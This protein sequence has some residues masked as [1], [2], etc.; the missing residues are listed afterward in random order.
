MIRGCPSS[1][2][3]RVPNLFRKNSCALI[4]PLL[5]PFRLSGCGTANHL[6]ILRSTGSKKT[7]WANYSVT[8]RVTLIEASTFWWERMSGGERTGYYVG[9]QRLRIGRLCRTTERNVWCWS[10]ESIMFGM[11]CVLSSPAHLVEFEEFLI[12]NLW[13]FNFTRAATDTVQ[14]H[15][16]SRRSGISQRKR[17]HLPTQTICLRQ[18]SQREFRGSC[19]I[20]STTAE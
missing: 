19:S 7:L 1:G 5:T 12:S 9:A 4:F 13:S 20:I 8:V 10:R 17:D 18:A 16:T 15:L 2:A 14:I 11:F 6:G 3:A